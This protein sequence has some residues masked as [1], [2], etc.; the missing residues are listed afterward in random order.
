[1]LFYILYIIVVV[2]LIYKP[3]QYYK[4]NVQE[5]FKLSR[6]E[7]TGLLVIL[8]VTGLRFDV[9]FDYMSYFHLVYPDLDELE[10]ERIEPLSVLLLRTAHLLQHPQYVFILFG[11]LTYLFFYLAFKENSSNF[12][13]SVLVYMSLFYLGDIS[14]LRQALACSVTMFAFQYTKNKQ[15]VRYVVV[16]AC[17]ALIHSSALIAIPIYFIY[18]YGSFFITIIS[19]SFIYTS[20]AALVYL[21]PGSDFTHFFDYMFEMNGGAIIK[22]VNIAI[23]VVLMVC[24]RITC[25]KQNVR[26]YYIVAIGLVFPFVFGSHLGNRIGTY[27][28]IYYC[29]MIANTMNKVPTA[30]YRF[31]VF[32]FMSYFVTTIYISTNSLGSQ[33]VPYRCVLFENIDNPHFRR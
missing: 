17:A 26:F 12:F 4:L 16:C 32:L 7:K 14:L 13:I 3:K 20:S 28:T 9:G 15:L 22:Y 19:V 30:V 33:Y 5:V 31:A 1:M 25:C 18:N 21:L 24:D 6:K 29:L 2:W 27:F 10:L 8:L 23:L 11:F